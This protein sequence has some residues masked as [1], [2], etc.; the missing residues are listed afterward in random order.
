MNQIILIVVIA[1]GRLLSYLSRRLGKG[2]GTSIPGLLVEKYFPSL[3]GSLG[4][5]Y[6]EVVLI[7][8]TNGKTT[9]RAIINKIYNDQGVRFISNIGGANIYRGIVT[10]LIQNRTWFGVLK[11]RVAILEVEEATL[12]KL[13]KYLK[14]TKLVF[15]NIFRDQLDV[16]GEINQTLDYFVAAIKQSD[17]QIIM[18]YDDKKLVEYLTPHIA[19]SSG[20]SVQTNS[21]TGFENSSQNTKTLTPEYLISSIKSGSTMEFELECEGTKKQLTSRLPGE[22]NLYNIAAAAAATYL[23]F[24]EN[25]Y[26]SIINFNNVF[27]R[28]EIINIDGS[29]YNLFLVKNPAGYNEVLKHLKS[30]N[31]NSLNL[32]FLINDNIADGRD[33]SW[34]W[35]VDFEG[36]L[37][38]QTLKTIFTGGK[39]GLDMLLRLEYAGANVTL[40]NNQSNYG[41]IITKTKAIGGEHYILCTYTALLEFRKEL[42]KL[43]EIP[44]ISSEGN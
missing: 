39:R 32:S 19:S 18:N 10:A 15:T 13:T 43:T 31:Q 17:A 34:L 14:P 11:S 9:T 27:G 26:E 36:F 5:G 1:F 40:E 24:K 12:P 16:Y 4:R 37:E 21:K 7:S 42:G 2:S 23:V 20:F 6:E 44:D 30:L 8:G 29:T 3:V 22:Y 33:V 28:G 25:I 41:D 35:D 38:N